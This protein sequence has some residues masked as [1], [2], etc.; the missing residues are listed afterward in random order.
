MTTN[1]STWKSVSDGQRFAL[2]D[3]VDYQIPMDEGS[4]LTLAGDGG[5]DASL[6]TDAWVDDA[7]FFGGTAPD[8]DGS[9]DYWVTDS[10]VDAINDD[11]ISAAKWIN[12]ESG[13]TAAAILGCMDSDGARA[14]TGWSVAFDD[15]GVTIQHDGQGSA[16]VDTDITGTWYM[17]GMALNGDSNNLFVFDNDGLVNSDSASQSRTTEEH[18]LGGMGRTSLG[19]W[20]DGLADV[21]MVG[22]GQTWSESDFDKIHA[23]TRRE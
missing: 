13:D 16:S 6:Q 4:G 3:L 23:A 10:Q 7:T 19:R 20:I 1:F 5:P 21:P 11:Q 18:H 12:A 17:V 15:P 22:F 8:F 2:P 9:S 14:E